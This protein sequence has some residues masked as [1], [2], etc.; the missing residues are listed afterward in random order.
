VVRIIK[1]LRLA[2]LRD[3]GHGCQAGILTA[4]PTETNAPVILGSVWLTAAPVTTPF[5]PSA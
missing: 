3:G 1:L 5:A 2:V 4:L